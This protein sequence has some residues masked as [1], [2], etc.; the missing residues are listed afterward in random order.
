MAI[1]KQVNIAPVLIGLVNWHGK[2]I[3]DEYIGDISQMEE[4]VPVN[5]VDEIVFC[6]KDIPSQE[7]I[8]TMLRMGDAAV[9][10]KIAPPESLSVI[11]SNSIN[12]AGEFYVVNINSLSHSFVKRKKRIFD[13]TLSIILLGFSPV[14]IFMVKKPLGYFR[15]IFQVAVKLKTWVGLAPASPTDSEYLSGILPGVLTP[16]PVSK[17]NSTGSE[18]IRRLN[19]LYAKDYKLSNDILIIIRDFKYLGN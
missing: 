17:E 2:W 12:T 10:F 1:L 16:L 9:E 5:H 13:L 18:T 3:S 6:A 11:G 19:L 8:Q 15:N 4:I 14:F 7:I